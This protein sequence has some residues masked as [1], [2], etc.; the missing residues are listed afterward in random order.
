LTFSIV[1]PAMVA[2]AAFRSAPMPAMLIIRRTGKR[3][4][5]PGDPSRSR[6]RDGQGSEALGMIIRQPRSPG[7]DRILAGRLDPD[8]DQHR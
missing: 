6:R 3:R 7:D 8:R 2:A 5:S 1:L 4:R